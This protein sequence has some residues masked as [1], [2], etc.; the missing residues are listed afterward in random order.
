MPNRGNLLAAIDQLAAQPATDS[1][2]PTVG[3]LH[4]DVDRFRSLND[5]PDRQCRRC[6]AGQTWSRWR[7]DN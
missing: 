1:H 3:L 7:A 2:S 4:L 5:T 6:P